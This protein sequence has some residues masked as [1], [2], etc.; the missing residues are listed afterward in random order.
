[1]H[2]HEEVEVLRRRTGRCKPP[3]DPRSELYVEAFLY[4]LE[5]DPHERNNLVSDPAYAE[6]RAELC[7]TLNRRMAE[8]GEALPEIVP[9]GCRRGPG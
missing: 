1:M 9:C 6:V 7:A 4:D 8:A 5:A 3:D 2:P